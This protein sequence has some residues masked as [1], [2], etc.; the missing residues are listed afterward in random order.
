MRT[1]SVLSLRLDNA[2][3]R[4]GKHGGPTILFVEIL[5]QSG[6]GWLRQSKLVYS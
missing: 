1:V 2:G 4:V 3:C 6:R 5:E